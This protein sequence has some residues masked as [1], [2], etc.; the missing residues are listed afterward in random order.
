MR[1]G[2]QIVNRFHQRAI[3]RDFAAVI[4]QHQ[5]ALRLCQRGAQGVDIIDGEWLAIDLPHLIQRAIQRNA[6]AQQRQIDQIARDGRAN[7]RRQRVRA[8]RDV[9]AHVGQNLHKLAIEEALGFQIRIIDAD[10][11]GHDAIDR[12]D[13]DAVIAVDIAVR[14]VPQRLLHD[15]AALFFRRVRKFGGVDHLIDHAMHAFQ[16]KQILHGRDIVFHRC[17]S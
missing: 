6:A 7:R 4:R 9:P 5:H 11:A 14:Q 3:Q 8:L 15:F 16:R 12:F 13:L 1:I 10:F 17:I 2:V